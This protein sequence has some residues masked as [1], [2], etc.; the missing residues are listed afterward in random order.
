MKRAGE[1]LSLTSSDLPRTC[2]GAICETRSVSVIEGH[3]L[4]A[5]TYDL[6]PNALLALEERALN[7]LLPALHGKFVIDV[8][9]GTG[10][11]LDKLKAGGASECVGVDLSVEMLS[12]ASQ[13]PH[14][15]GSLIRGDA[16]A[17]PIRSRVADVV[18]CSFAVGYIDDLRAFA[19]ELSRVSRPHGLVVVSDFH[20]A[21]H[22]RGW[23]RTFR[24]GSEVYEI[25]SFARPT[26]QIRDEFEKCGLK[27][28]TC[29]EPCIDEPERYLFEAHGNGQWFE[30][31]RG[32][33]A[34]FLC[35]FRRIPGTL[36]SENQR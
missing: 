26:T 35:L 16:C 4:W 33:P 22:S 3:S 27:L 21:N 7:S 1:V 31:I 34:V 9:C 8:A 29:S 2:G 30:N 18:L 12:Q 11:W 36:S 10:R 25:R 23:R 32:N 14:L 15:N 6:T 19:G 24:L 20:P 13:K 5:K 28:E 17:L